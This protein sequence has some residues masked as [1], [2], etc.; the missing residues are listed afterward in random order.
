MPI[1]VPCIPLSEE[2]E[3]LFTRL[4]ISFVSGFGAYNSKQ[5]S[6]LKYT[7]KVTHPPAAMTFGQYEAF[8]L[9]SYAPLDN[10]VRVDVA[11]EP[12]S[13]AL[14]GIIFYYTDGAQRSVGQYRIGYNAIQTYMNPAC[15]C[16]RQEQLQGTRPAAHILRVTGS[17]SCHEGH[18][19][20]TRE[21]GC[22]C[23]RLT[24]FIRAQFDSE[25][26]SLHFA[27]REAQRA[28]TM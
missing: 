26:I 1:N 24:G 23:Y 15:L 5:V 3:M 16:L 9:T 7:D 19:T 4:Q 17:P 27:D 6:Q 10:I 13:E 12:I 2:P 14:Q 8:K 11:V 18:E 20:H 28:E 21:N 25:S 22:T